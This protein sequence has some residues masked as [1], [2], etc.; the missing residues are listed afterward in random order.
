LFVAGQRVIVNA[1]FLRPEEQ[2]AGKK[3]VKKSKSEDDGKKKAK[4]GKTSFDGQSEDNSKN[5]EILSQISEDS[6][7]EDEKLFK[8]EDKEGIA[9]DDYSSE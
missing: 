4:A 5:I 8:D 2:D 1:P 9:N 6:K 7:S 3:K